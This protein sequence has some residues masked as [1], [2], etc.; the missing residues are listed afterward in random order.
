[1]AG[2]D[3]NRWTVLNIPAEAMENDPLGRKPGESHD[4]ARQRTP[5]Q[6]E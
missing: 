2:E 3:A 5:K 1:M 4:S 6:W